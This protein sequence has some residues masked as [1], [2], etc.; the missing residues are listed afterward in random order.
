MTDTVS[1]EVG[2]FPDGIAIVTD[3]EPLRVQ[4]AAGRQLTGRSTLPDGTRLTVTVENVSGPA[5]RLSERVTVRDG[6][7]VATFDFSGL[8]TGQRFTVTVEQGPVVRDRVTG[9]VVP[10]ARVS[11]DASATY[12]ALTLDSVTLPDGGYVVVTTLDG[13]RVVASDR[14]SPGSYQGLTLTF[15][16]TPPLGE[17]EFVVT[18]RRDDGDGVLDD[19]DPP[20]RLQGAAVSRVVSVTVPTPRTQTTTATVTATPTRQSTPTATPTPTTT[21]AAADGATDGGAGAGFSFAAVFVGIVVLVL[22]LL[23]L[24]G[25]G[26]DGDG[27]E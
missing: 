3:E 2:L 26:R 19:G 5:F 15:E 1:V 18:L 20:Y 25:P 6:R 11:P 17:Q 4:Q 7:F 22:V 9:E 24:F 10:R 12:E 16:E 13:K 8:P 23:I 27:G 14:L 21:P